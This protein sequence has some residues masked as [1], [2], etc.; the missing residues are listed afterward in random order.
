MEKFWDFKSLEW[1]KIQ[2][3]Q[4]TM[5]GERLGFQVSRMAKIQLNQSAM[6]REILIF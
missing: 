3:N 5:V 4:S 2:S 1:L 6:V